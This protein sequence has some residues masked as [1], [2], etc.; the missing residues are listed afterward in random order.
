MDIYFWQASI[1][2]SLQKSVELTKHSHFK[3]A[4]SR[5]KRERRINRLILSHNPP[6]DLEASVTGAS[7]LKKG[8]INRQSYVKT[9]HI[10][11]M[12]VAQLRTWGFT[13]ESKPSDIGLTRQSYM[14][15]AQ[16]FDLHRC[17]IVFIA[18]GRCSVNAGY[19]S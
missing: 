10:F 3:T 13:P 7:N 17:S 18:R 16:K 1:F 14:Y 11:D 6:T 12:Q 8:R 4:K 5:N 19:Q 2:D 15:L 9:E